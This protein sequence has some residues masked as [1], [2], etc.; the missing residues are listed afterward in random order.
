[1]PQTSRGTGLRPCRL[2]KSQRVLLIVDFIT[3]LDFPG[4]EKLAA[5]ALVAAR[6]TAALKQRLQAEQVPAIYANDNYGVWQSD[7]HSLVS[8]CLGLEGE[9]GQIARVLYPQADDITILKPRHSAFY[10]SALEL[11]LTEM[12]AREL[13]ICG[14]A[15]DMCVQMTAADAFLREFKVWVPAD[16]T[17]A[18]TKE[19]KAAALAYMGSVL[20]CDVRP[21][22]AGEPAIG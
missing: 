16:C 9:A 13:V 6:A 1:M 8:T 7:F 15:T 3:S 14:L 4:A 11:L 12:E 19:A 22:T 2:P 10:A 17:A 21:S 18:E 20:K 5:P